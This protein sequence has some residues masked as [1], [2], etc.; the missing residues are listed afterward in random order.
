MSDKPVYVCRCECGGKVYGVRQFN[1]L[2]SWCNRCTP[3][4]KVKR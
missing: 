2:W 1:R 4:V 3:I